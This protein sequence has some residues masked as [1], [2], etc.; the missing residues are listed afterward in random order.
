[1]DVRQL[2]YFLAVVET[3]NF[4]R[5]A[6]QLYIAQPSLSQAIGTLERELGVPL[7]HR[8]GRGIVL[9]DAGAQLIEPARQVVRDLEAARAAA[10]SVH[11]LQR[12]RVELIAMPSP[13]VEPL[14]TLIRDFTA[15]HPA[16]TVTADAAFTPEEVVHAVKAGRSELGLLGAASPPHTGGLRVL[17]I[18]DQPLVLL[19]PPEDDAPQAREDPGSVDD[20]ATPAV[21]REAL[22]G[23]RL[24]VSRRGSL[25]RGLVDDVLA[26]G[27]D[28]Q[29]VVEVEHRTSILPLV[30]AGVGHAVL[31]SSW[32][33]LAQR[34]GAR[35]RRIEPAVLLRIALVFR[36]GTLTPAAQAFVRCAERHVSDQETAAGPVALNDRPGL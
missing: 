9:S 10:R 32:A 8:V 6:E 35:V 18:E 19:S 13:G 14:S 31:P 2:T 12:G 30:L 28:A 27:V 5:A 25:M 33:P 7:F 16:M 1:M 36:T 22:A 20:P 17:P 4:G 23:A 34:S 3:M 11:E 21:A 26:S 24:I 15:A 29:V